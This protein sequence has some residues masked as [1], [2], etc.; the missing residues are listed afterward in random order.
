MIISKNSFNQVADG[1]PNWLC[2]TQVIDH[3]WWIW[4]QTKADQRCVTFLLLLTDAT[5]SASGDCGG[6]GGFRFDGGGEGGRRFHPLGLLLLH[7]LVSRD[8]TSLLLLSPEN[9]FRRQRIIF[10]TKK[11]PPP[12]QKPK[13]NPKKPIPPVQKP[14]KHHHSFHQKIISIY[15]FQQQL[16]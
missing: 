5:A 2:P 4:Q 8:T 3:L 12:V 11:P 15:Y 14:K 16:L 10:T 1:G 7:H 13:L 6:D 9:Q